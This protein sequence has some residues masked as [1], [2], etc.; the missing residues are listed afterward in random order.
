MLPTPPAQPLIRTDDGNSVSY[1]IKAPFTMS[2]DSDGRHIRFSHCPK[3]RFP[4]LQYAFDYFH[5]Q[6]KLHSQRVIQDKWQQ[7]FQAGQQSFDYQQSLQFTQQDF[8][9]IQ[10]SHAVQQSF[11]PQQSLQFT[12]QD[13]QATQ[14]SHAVQQIQD[15]QMHLSI[16][17]RNHLKYLSLQ[18][19]LHNQRV[20]QDKWQQH[21]QAGQQ[22]FDPQQSLQFTQQDFQAIQQRQAVQQVQAAQL[23]LA[24]HQRNHLEYLSLQA[25]QLAKNAAQRGY[26]ANTLST[27]GQ[28]RRHDIPL[29]PNDGLSLVET[30]TPPRSSGSESQYQHGIEPSAQTLWEERDPVY[31]TGSMRRG[32]SWKSQECGVDS[33]ERLRG[34][35]SGPNPLPC[36]YANTILPQTLYKKDRR[37]LGVPVSAG[38]DEIRAGFWLRDLQYTT[39]RCRATTLEERAVASLKLTR[40]QEAVDRLCGCSEKY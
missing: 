33:A 14:Q 25:E 30:P 22:S 23:H 11:D 39:D 38:I 24:V 20:I 31:S 13:V 26:V 21:F 10:Q 1:F 40:A 19:K 5:V 8:Q 18:E 37:V 2:W 6:E 36:S 27:C 34:S 16:Y 17:P 28:A 4:S 3:L 35:D 32:W 12:Q 7:H 9:A 29:K 15:V